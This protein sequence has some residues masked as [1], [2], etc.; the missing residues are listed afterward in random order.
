MARLK[1]DANEDAT[2]STLRSTSLEPLVTPRPVVAADSPGP[3]NHVRPGSLRNQTSWRLRVAAVFL[4]DERARGG[5]VAHAVQVFERLA[6]HQPAERPR[7]FRARLFASSARISS[8]RPRA[9]CS[10]TRRAT[11][12][13]SCAAGSVSPIASTSMSGIGDAVS[14]KCAVSGRPVRKI[15]LERA[16]DP[17]L[18]ARLN[19]WPPTPDR[20]AAASDAAVRR[21]A[22][23]RSRPGAPASRRRARDRETGRASA[24][25]NKSRSR[26][27]QSA[28][29][30]ARECRG[31]IAAASRAYCAAVYSPSGST[32][33]IR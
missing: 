2:V 1:G 33:S 18:I 4:D 7:V 25:E 22:S 15:H 30:R 6:I 16:D 23:P 31:S 17:L 12:A 5:L 29:A 20:P 3:S 19:P 27:R 10:S 21:P 24:R 14:A 26:R 9:N 13:A 8:S 28:A 11:R 32:M